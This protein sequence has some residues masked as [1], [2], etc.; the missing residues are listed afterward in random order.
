M[1]D[2]SWLWRSA[3]NAAIQ[4]CAEWG[5]AGRQIAELFEIAN[6]VSGLFESLVTPLYLGRREGE[7]GQRTISDTALGCA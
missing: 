6:I 3:Y 5:D 2:I 7:H 1:K 4:G